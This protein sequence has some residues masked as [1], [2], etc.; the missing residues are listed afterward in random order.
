MTNRETRPQLLKA[1]K[2]LVS[3]AFNQHIYTSEDNFTALRWVMERDIN[4][5]SFR[6][7]LK[8]DWYTVRESG[9]VLIWLM[10]RGTRYYDVKTR[11]M[12]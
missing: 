3:P 1:Y 12:T 7:E 5:K 2:D 6:L 4:L 10:M 11:V 8:D 9:E